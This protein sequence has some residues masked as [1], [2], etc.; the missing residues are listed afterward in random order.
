MD[1]E[2]VS[3]CFVKA[4]L[5]GVYARGLDAEALLLQAGIQPNLLSAPQA[6]VPAAHY[7]A[8][9]RSIAQLLDDEFLGL[10]SRR[11]KVG[12]FAMLC[13]TVIHCPTL[14][15]ALSRTA[16]FYNLL[17]DNFSIVVTR[18]GDIA[19]LAL[20]ERRRRSSSAP[21]VLVHEGLLIA[22]HGLACWLVG[23]RIPITHAEFAYPEPAHSAEYRAMFYAELRFS[24]P[25]TSVAFDAS[26][27]ELPVVQDEQSVKDF[28]RVMP[29]NLLVKYKNS[30]S[31]SAKIRA[32]LRESLPCELP[33]LATIAGEMHTTPATLRRRLLDEGESYQSIKN[34]LRHDLALTYLSHPERSVMD[35]ALELGFAEPSA[36][37]RAFKKW[38]GASPGEHR[39]NTIALPADEAGAC[40]KDQLN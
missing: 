27:L 35:I 23:R 15:R 18:N 31:L 32:R 2:M 12:S 3:I 26:Y 21:N 30:N 14:E 29:D 39:R 13:R 38:T 8:L 33:Q 28:L 17:V 7:A 22:L 10:D 4:S 34:R 40:G 36:F 1:K 24:R 37:H 16:R 9:W 20:R 5:Q 19:T 6:R 11:V 25:S